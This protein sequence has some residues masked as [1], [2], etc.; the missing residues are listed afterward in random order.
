MGGARASGLMWLRQPSALDPSTQSRHPSGSASKGHSNACFTSF[1]PTAFRQPTPFRLCLRPARHRTCVVG[2]SGGACCTTVASSPSGIVH[3]ISITTDRS[4][5]AG[6]QHIHT[7]PAC[8]LIR[9]HAHSGVPCPTQDT[10][11]SNIECMLR[12]H[13]PPAL[14]ECFLCAVPMH[15]L[16]MGTPA[17]R[18][19]RHCSMNY[20]L[21]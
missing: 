3:L 8:S 4:A 15:P 17:H 13:G 20:Q 6:T 1:Q 14:T 12:A 7:Q 18:K 11:H 21:C 10:Y 9:H 16:K 2:S 19:M 5:D